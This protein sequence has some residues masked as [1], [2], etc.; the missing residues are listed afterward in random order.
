MSDRCRCGRCGATVW[1]RAYPEGPGTTDTVYSRLLQVPAHKRHERWEGRRAADG[2]RVLDA[3]HE[4][5]YAAR[6]A[7]RE[8][9]LNESRRV[10]MDALEEYDG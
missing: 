9:R 2:E 7:Q 1:R 10:F 6:K 5:M 3:C 4:A 8:R